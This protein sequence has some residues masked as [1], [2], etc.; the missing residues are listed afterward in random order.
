MKAGNNI[1]EPAVSNSVTTKREMYLA[2]KG[3]TVICKGM[4]NGSKGTVNG[5]EYTKL[6]IDQIRTKVFNMNSDLG[7]I[8]TSD[9]T[10]MKELLLNMPL[11]IDDLSSW[12]TS[13]VKDMSRM[14]E[15]AEKFNSDISYWDTSKVT[16]MT[17]MFKDAIMFR[18]DLSNWDVSNVESCNEFAAG[19]SW[20]EEEQPDLTCRNT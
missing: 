5:K 15:Y 20:D 18:Q 6:N 8:C 4:E 11:Y 19:T 13:Q 16:D 12:D 2:S 3:V 7:T 9:I 14:F 10:D 17:A 1:G